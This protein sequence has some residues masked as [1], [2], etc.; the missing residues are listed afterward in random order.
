M[1]NDESLKRA[2]R[3]CNAPFHDY[4]GH[5]HEFCSH[6]TMIAKAIDEAVA[7]AEARWEVKW[8][9][10][11]K[12]HEREL[13]NAV[14]EEREANK[15][16]VQEKLRYHWSIAPNSLERAL[17]RDAEHWA[18]DAIRARGEASDGG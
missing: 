12:R 3:E 17:L 9:A 16:A 1:S 4:P 18:L 14:A 15:H 8:D 13:T 5:E 7:E 2:R 11:C 6:C 10:H